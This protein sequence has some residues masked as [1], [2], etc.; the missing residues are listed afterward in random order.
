MLYPVAANSI[1]V[2]SVTFVVKFMTGHTLCI[3]SDILLSKLAEPYDW[4][5]VVYP[6]HGYIFPPF[7]NL[8][9]DVLSY[10]F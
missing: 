4:P 1:F 9:G 10:V 3:I 8:L 2:F 6:C 5:V 7:F